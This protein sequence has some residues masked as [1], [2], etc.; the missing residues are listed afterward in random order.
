MM[1]NA[2]NYAI[3]WDERW[4]MRIRDAMF[5]ESSAMGLDASYI[6]LRSPRSKQQEERHGVR[7]LAA[8]LSDWCNSRRVCLGGQGC[9]AARIYLRLDDRPHH[10]AAGRG[11]AV[12]VDL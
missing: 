11:G 8:N 5:T 6:P 9:R 3:V 12:R 2:L 10:H 1:G 7:D 4:G